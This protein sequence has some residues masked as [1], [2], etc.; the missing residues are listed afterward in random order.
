MDIISLALVGQSACVSSQP[1]FDRC[2]CYP[3]VPRVSEAIELMNT[4]EV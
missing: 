2:S 3:I 4:I 1:G